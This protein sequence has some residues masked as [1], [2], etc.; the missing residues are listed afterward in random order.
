MSSLLNDENSFLYFAFG[1]NLLTE[2]I[3]LNNPSA[4]K[5]DIAKLQVEESKTQTISLANVDIFKS[6]KNNLFFFQDYTLDFNQFSDRW[7]GAIATV[8][9]KKGEHV[10]GVLWV[11]KNEDLKNLDKWVAYIAF[12]SKN[13]FK[14]NP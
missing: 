3:H 1:S 10:Y 11:I 5:L 9:E 12:V 13:E 2:R 6:W 4:K 8:Y 7:K 14:S